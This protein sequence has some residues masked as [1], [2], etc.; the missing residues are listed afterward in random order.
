MNAHTPA[1]VGRRLSTVNNMVKLPAYRD[2]FTRSSLRHL[3][4]EATPRKNSKGTVLPTNGMLEAGV[5]VRV[6][7][8]VLIDL[9][10]FDAW[11]DG[12]RTKSE[13]EAAW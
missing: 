4:F 10:A 8:K 12:M 13:W 9:D 6:G 11:L 5:I 1:T 7:R 3:I 2:A